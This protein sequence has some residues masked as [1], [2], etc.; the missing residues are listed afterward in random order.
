MSDKSMLGMTNPKHKP[1]KV[2][3]LGTD[4]EIIET[5]ANDEPRL[6]NADGW[7][8]YYDNQILIE[9]NA[10]KHHQGGDVELL[11]T[12]YK[13]FIKRHEICHAFFNESALDDYNRNE[14]LVTWIARQFPKMLKAFEQV[15]AI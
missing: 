9:S 15:D 7:C 6:E 11:K 2:N 14:Q 12:E 13:K 5:T 10:F 3:I 8:G 4:Y 1:E